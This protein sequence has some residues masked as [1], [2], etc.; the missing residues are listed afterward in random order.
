MTPRRWGFG[1]LTIPPVS[2]WVD[3]TE[4]GEPFSFTKGESGVGALQFTI[5]L[6]RAGQ[7]PN[8]DVSVLQD[9]LK[10]FQ[11]TRGLGEPLSETSLSGMPMVVSRRYRS[12]SDF[13]HV[14][15]VSDGLS[16]A[17]VTY[18]CE[19]D[20]RDREIHEVEEIVSGIRFEQAG[21]A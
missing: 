6:Y 18:V 20:S 4:P 16:V 2:G 14:S 11:E 1:G 19:W 7:L 13:I 5:V 17:L 8:I 9:M 12:E 15:Y 3:V 10:E 21:R